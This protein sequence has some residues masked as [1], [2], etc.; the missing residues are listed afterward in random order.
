MYGIIDFTRID[1]EPGAAS[2]FA[3]P[4]GWDGD[5]VAYRQLMR[6]RWKADP[7]VRQH[8]AI[9]GRM[10]ARGEQVEFRGRFADEARRIAEATLKGG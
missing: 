4:A 8:V 6:Q 1:T 10:L 5:G 9:V 3:P 2:A 7:G